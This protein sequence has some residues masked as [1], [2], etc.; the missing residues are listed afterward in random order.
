MIYGSGKTVRAVKNVDRKILLVP[1]MFFVLRI[2]GVIRF[3][4]YF[5]RLNSTDKLTTAEKTFILLQV[6]EGNFNPSV[7][8]ISESCIKI[9]IN[10][11]F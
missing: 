8:C 7:P 4:L 5:T 3:V 9:K 1:I 10:L 11:N 2:W 6:I